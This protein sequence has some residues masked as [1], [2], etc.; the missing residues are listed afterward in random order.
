MTMTLTTM[1]GQIPTDTGDGDDTGS[2]GTTSET[3][4]VDDTGTSST[5]EPLPE[6]PGRCVEL[7]PEGWSGPVATQTS[8]PG[9]K[10][11]PCPRGFPTN[12]VEGFDDFVAPPAE[13]GCECGAPQGI[14]C[15]QIGTLRSYGTAEAC[16][17][18]VVDT[19]NLTNGVCTG[20]SVPS[21]GFVRLE[22]VEVLNIGSCQASS[23]VELPEP[24]FD[25][26][27][28]G[29][30]A[31]V[32][33]GFSCDSAQAM[34]CLPKEAV[35]P[36]TSRMCIWQEGEHECPE[37]TAYIDDWIVYN[38]FEDDRDCTDCSC[39]DPVGV[40]DNASVTLYSSNNC[41][42]GL[43]GIATGE[44]FCTEIATNS[45]TGRFLA[46]SPTA[47]CQ[48]ADVEPTGEVVQSEPITLCCTQ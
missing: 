25:T 3:G 23:T 4:G 36:A 48:E 40:C 8:D 42:L 37:D 35:A 38:D 7:A 21:S 28:T 13:C 11:P 1:T 12:A 41:L 18:P 9:E 43:T 6:C 44:G 46:G 39:D 20:V 47:F 2:G 10:A 24:S 19:T 29:C 22:P 5:G 33:T 27:V 30:E 17:G 26:R 31:E 16:D 32:Q 34:G 15:N 14:L 45:I